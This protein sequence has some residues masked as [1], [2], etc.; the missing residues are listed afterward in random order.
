MDFIFHHDTPLRSYYLFVDAEFAVW[1]RSIQLRHIYKSLFRQ[2]AKDQI[3]S[4]P[5]YADIIL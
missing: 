1:S 2:E 4:C 5:N 3:I